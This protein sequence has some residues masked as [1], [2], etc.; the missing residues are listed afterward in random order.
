MVKKSVTKILSLGLLMTACMMHASVYAEVRLHP[1]FGDCMVLQQQSVTML[2]GQ[3]SPGK[4]VSVKCSWD[5][6]RQTTRVA[7]D[8]SWQ[9]AISTP[10]GGFDPQWI[11]IREANT[12]RLNDVLIGEVWLC[13]GQSNMEMP[14]QGFPSQPVE[15]SLSEISRA[16][17]YKNLRLFN[18]A[19]SYAEAPQSTCGGEW[20][21]CTP[22]HVATFSAIGY[23]FG[24][25]LTEAL[26]MPVGIIVSSYGG[27][28]IESW[29]DAA[30]I[31]KFDPEDYIAK[32]DKPY[33]D[34][35]KL[36]NA[37]IAPLVGSSIRGVV[38]LQG[39]SNRRNAH[40]YAPMLT[41]L[42]ALWRTLWQNLRMPFIVCQIAPCPYHGEGELGAARLME[43]QYKAVNSDDHA[44]LVGTSDVGAERFIHYPDKKIVA[45]RV[46]VS[47][48]ANVYKIKGLPVSGP[49]MN[50]IE[51]GDHKAIVHFNHAGRGLVPTD[52]DIT[53]FQLAGADLVF[54]PAKARIGRKDRTTVEVECEEVSHPC[55][56]RYAFSNWHRVNLY[57]CEGLPAYPFRTDSIQYR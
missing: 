7:A 6:A 23:L 56:V 5:R 9:V 51:Y 54:Y 18:V 22:E 1:L 40:V 17:R 24:R 48:L 19:H 41:E 38:W 25:R 45:E 16:F 29:L 36:F 11:E 26:D 47:A 53:C 34:P 2:R 55:A 20:M 39:E 13:A 32:A 33:R 50:R 37:M 31:K 52:R 30:S 15:G 43:A 21:V 27:S 35:C 8:G 4:K 44:Y 10:S 3:A 28:R 57:N 12:I 14:M 49:T 46:F 42:M